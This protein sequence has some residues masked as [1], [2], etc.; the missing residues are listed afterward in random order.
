MS[1]VHRVIR[2]IRSSFP[3]VMRSSAV[4]VGSLLYASSVLLV[5]CTRV[6]LA[7]VVYDGTG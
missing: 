3:A 5:P 7:R 6:V 4:V 1:L 2:S